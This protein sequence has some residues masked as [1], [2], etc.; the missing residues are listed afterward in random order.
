M[1][2]SFVFWQDPLIVPTH[3]HGN[4]LEC[5]ESISRAEIGD[6]TIVCNSAAKSGFGAKLPQLTGS[7]KSLARA[8]RDKD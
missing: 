2:D 8:G 7:P 4:T 6:K 3:W 5:S 1:I